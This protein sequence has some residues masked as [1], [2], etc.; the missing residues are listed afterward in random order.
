MKVIF[1]LSTCFIVSSFIALN[2]DKISKA[3]C[4][5][6]SINVQVKYYTEHCSHP[7]VY[8]ISKTTKKVSSIVDEREWCE[9]KKKGEPYSHQKKNRTAY[10]RLRLFHIHSASISRYNHVSILYAI[11]AI[12]HL[13]SPAYLHQ[14]N[15]I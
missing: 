12:Q 2:M 3:R 10:I 8:N 1:L 6:F 7:D 13:V 4:A 15:N 11:A 5:P 14:T 9:A